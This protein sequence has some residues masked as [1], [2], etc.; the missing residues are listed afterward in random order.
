MTF[1]RI[2]YKT[3]LKYN[4]TSHFNSNMTLKGLYDIHV[5][6]QLKPLKVGYNC[7]NSTWQ[8]IK[9]GCL[10]TNLKISLIINPKIL[11]RE[12]TF[13]RLPLKTFISLD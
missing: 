5:Y 9:I 10:T 7:N 2:I 1:Y 4:Q 12:N 6:Y 8:R 11:I 13:G 3:Q